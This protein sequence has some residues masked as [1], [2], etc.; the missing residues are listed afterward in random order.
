MGANLIENE[1]TRGDDLLLSGRFLRARRHC[2][3]HG[4]EQPAAATGKSHRLLIG[5]YSKHIV[6]IV[7]ADG[8]IEWSAPIV[9][10]HDAWLLPDGN[11][12]FQTNWQTIVEMTPDSREVWRYDA[13]R[14]RMATPDGRSRSTPFSDCPMARR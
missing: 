10:I 6:A 11:V 12:L 2:A 14:S 9:D 8:E 7:S 4:A 3:A 13:G 5:D 1:K